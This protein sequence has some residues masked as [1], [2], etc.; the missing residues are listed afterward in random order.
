MSR[1]R[2]FADIDAELDNQ[3]EQWG[4]DHDFQ[5]TP[6]EYIGLKIRYIGKAHQALEPKSVPTNA[7][8]ENRRGYTLEPDLDEYRRRLV[9]DAAITVSAIR[10]LDAQRGRTQ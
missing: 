8:E 6:I 1:A 2:V 10:A 7:H 9:Q 3:A 4:D 5:H